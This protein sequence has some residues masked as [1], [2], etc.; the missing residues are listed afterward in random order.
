MGD[1]TGGGSGMPFVS[2][3]PNGW[4]VRFS[5][6]PMFNR[7]G[8]HTEHGIAPDIKVDITTEDFARSIDTI[9]EAARKHLKNAKP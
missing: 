5:A 9:I 8:E 1:Q 2:E 4:M 6:C 7:E 3:L